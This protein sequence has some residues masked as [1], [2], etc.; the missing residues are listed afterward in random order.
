MRL[1]ITKGRVSQLISEGRLVAERLTAGT[2]VTFERAETY[3]AGHRS[4]GRPKKSA[5]M[6]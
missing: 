3:A 6:A 5:A 1:G 2:Q 4:P